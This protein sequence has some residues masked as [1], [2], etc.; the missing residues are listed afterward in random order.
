M[1]EFWK[2]VNKCAVFY[3]SGGNDKRE[4]LCFV[5]SNGYLFLWASSGPWCLSS[6]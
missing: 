6:V 2:V 4:M 5:S 3:Y 1:G